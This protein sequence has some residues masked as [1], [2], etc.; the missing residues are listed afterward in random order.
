MILSVLFRYQGAAL[1][2]RRLPNV[3]IWTSATQAHMFLRIVFQIYQMDGFI[4]KT[5]YGDSIPLDPSFGPAF[6]FN[7]SPYPEDFADPC[8]S[9]RIDIEAALSRPPRLSIPELIGRSRRNSAE[10]PGEQFAAHQYSIATNPSSAR[11]R[12]ASIRRPRHIG[13]KASKEHLKILPRSSSA[14]PMSGKSV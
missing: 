14:D 10:N 2:H 6:P 1:D 8:Q 7:M 12:S 13:N 5:R 11:N 9:N 4:K 3:R